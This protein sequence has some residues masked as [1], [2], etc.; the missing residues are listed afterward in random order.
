MLFKIPCKAD[1]LGFIMNV[2]VAN[3]IA[4]NLFYYQPLP[5]VL[6]YGIITLQFTF[7]DKLMINCYTLKYNDL[8]SSLEK[9]ANKIT[10]KT[11]IIY[12]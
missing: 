12:M 9:H 5:S 11:H 10:Y 2:C 6:E 7:N 3:K 4:K 8:T 1:V